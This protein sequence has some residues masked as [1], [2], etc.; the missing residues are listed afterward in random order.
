MSIETKQDKYFKLEVE[1]E[2]NT[3][4]IYQKDSNIVI[5]KDAAKELYKI[6]GDFID[7]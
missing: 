2:K 1:V 3:V 4:V 6:L 7:G 5:S